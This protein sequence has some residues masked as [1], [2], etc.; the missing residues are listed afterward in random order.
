M[1]SF[2]E[3]INTAYNN[4]PLKSKITKDEFADIFCKGMAYT[5]SQWNEAIVKMDAA[6]KELKT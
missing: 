5:A 3:V 4:S 6:I 1:E 2:D